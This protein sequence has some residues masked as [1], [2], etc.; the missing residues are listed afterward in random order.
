MTKVLIIL[1]VIF[2]VNK[3][4]AYRKRVI[5]G[6]IRNLKISPE[7]ERKL[8]FLAT[9][10]WERAVSAGIK[11]PTNNVAVLRLDNDP[12]TWVIMKLGIKDTELFRCR[13]S[14]DDVAEASEFARK[15][16]KEKEEGA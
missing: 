7:E 8:R 1:A 12:Y 11:I 5:R 9:K 2:I 15:E 4:M 10:C 6:K 3:F 13:M 16:N 14:I